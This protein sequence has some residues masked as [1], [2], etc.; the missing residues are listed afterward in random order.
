MRFIGVFANRELYVIY[1][2]MYSNDFREVD[3]DEK[4]DYLFD[5]D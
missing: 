1:A 4:F 3:N 2:E 5:D